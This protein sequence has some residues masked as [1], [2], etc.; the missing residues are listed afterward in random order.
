MF[1]ISPPKQK[2]IF[3]YTLEVCGVLFNFVTNLPYLTIYTTY[4]LV[5]EYIPLE[6]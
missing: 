5:N 3:E 2:G 4:E 6:I 1:Y